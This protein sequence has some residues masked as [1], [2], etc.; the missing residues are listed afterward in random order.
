MAFPTIKK[1][2][3]LVGAVL[4]AVLGWR[5]GLPVAL[6]FLLGG[7]AA[8]AADPL[9]NLL[10]R[11]LRL[12]RPAASGIGVTAVL[13]GVLTLLIFLTAL[14]L[15]QLTGL[16]GALPRLVSSARESLGSLHAVL[17]DLSHRA[18]RNIQPLLNRAVDSVFTDGGAV[19]DSVLKRLPA[20]A[21]A[22]LGCITDSAL[23]VGTG[24]LSAY[25]ISARLPALRAWRSDLPQDSPLARVFPKL[26]RIRLALLGW[27][28]AQVKL[29]GI[30]FLILLTGFLL[31]KLPH[32]PLLALLIAL[33]DAIPLLGTGTVLVPWA[34]VCFLQGQNLRAM[35][36]L[37]IYAAA[38]LSRSAL[39]PRL[40]GKQ[41]GLDSLLTLVSL[42]AGYR[43]WGFGGMLIAPLLCVVVKEAATSN[44][45]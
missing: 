1:G 34:L 10:N 9:V 2:L 44:E 7:L 27:L 26:S 41:L 38:A 13:L 36:L 11:R 45:P 3:T 12:P 31:L 21:T 33:V 39:E 6:P 8:L 20:A 37:G 43:F 18:P 23:A 30:C 24:C 5:Y 16:T 42:Y 4:V 40:V 15:R 32:A 17:T 22:V 35:G 29:C 14:A 25:M 19:L 28:K